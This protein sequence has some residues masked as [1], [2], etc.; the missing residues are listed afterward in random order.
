[1]AAR[2]GTFWIERHEIA[3]RTDRA[4]LHLI[5]HGGLVAASP[6]VVLCYRFLKGMLKF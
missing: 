4:I 2:S 6:P 5:P 1:M 3:D